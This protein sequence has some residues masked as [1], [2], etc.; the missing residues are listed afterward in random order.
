[1]KFLLTTVTLL[2]LKKINSMFNDKM[3]G[4]VLCYKYHC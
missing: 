2:A 3:V 4:S 1:M